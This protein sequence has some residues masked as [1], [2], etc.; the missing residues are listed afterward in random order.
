MLYRYWAVKVE[1]LFRQT[2]WP[3]QLPDVGFNFLS[4]GQKRRGMVLDF[5]NA[6]W[7]A[8]PGPIGLDGSGNQTLGAPEILTRR[9]HR[10]VNFN[11]YF[12]AP[13]P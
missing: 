11:A 5:E 3:L 13:P 2:G 12:G 7:V 6:E 9:V 4:G 8:S 10:E 1:I